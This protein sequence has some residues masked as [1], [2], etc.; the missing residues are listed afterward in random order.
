MAQD[1][2]EIEPGG[3]VSTHRYRADVPNSRRGGAGD[4]V[5]F[6]DFVLNHRQRQHTSPG[7]TW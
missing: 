3:T 6:R 1:Y 4:N 5:R 7:Y 2:G